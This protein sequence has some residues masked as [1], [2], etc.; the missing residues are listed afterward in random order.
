VQEV[1]KPLGL[2]GFEGIQVAVQAEW[3]CI[4]ARKTG[5]LE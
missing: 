2:L 5:V 4:T 3:A 1:E